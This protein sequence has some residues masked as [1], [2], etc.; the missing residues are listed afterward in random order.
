[1]CE[2]RQ[3]GRSA[4][5]TTPHV[6]RHSLARLAADLGCNEPTIATLLGHK[7]HSIT[8]DPDP[9]TEV[10][11]HPTPSA[12][13]A[14]FATA[15]AAASNTGIGGMHVLAKRISRGGRNHRTIGVFVPR[16]IG[17][18]IGDLGADIAQ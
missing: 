18:I 8:S 5:G 12:F 2:D 6:L 9:A 1:V 11:P 15:S 14:A 16:E 4:A 13:M 17:N 10:A 3:A 7:A